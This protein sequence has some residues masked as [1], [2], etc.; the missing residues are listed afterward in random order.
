MVLNHIRLQLRPPT[1]GLF[2]YPWLNEQSDRSPWVAQPILCQNL[3]VRRIN[4]VELLTI[5]ADRRVV[6]VA[7][8]GS[9]LWYGHLNVPPTI[10]TV[11]NGSIVS[12]IIHQLN[13]VWFY[14]H[15][16]FVF[17]S[18]T[19]SKLSTC[20]MIVMV[21]GSAIRFERVSCGMSATNLGR[22]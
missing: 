13:V 8:V 12:P 16:N 18:W 11:I 1:G 6:S 17:D 5:R 2:F 14:C 15:A 20:A 7:V 3:A 9:H 22:N 19:T 10:G 21:Q 4:R